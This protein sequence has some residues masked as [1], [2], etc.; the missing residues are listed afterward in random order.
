[1]DYKNLKSR[2][3]LILPSQIKTV[4]SAIEN[5]KYGQL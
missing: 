2:Y 3:K 5:L 1:M 4:Y